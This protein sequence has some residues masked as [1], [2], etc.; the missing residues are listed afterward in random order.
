[1]CC[2]DKEEYKDDFD[3]LSRERVREHISEYFRSCL[4]KQENELLLMFLIRHINSY[5]TFGNWAV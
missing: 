5:E 2:L 4:G 3:I 1:M